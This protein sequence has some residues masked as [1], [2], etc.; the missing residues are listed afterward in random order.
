MRA[1]FLPLCAFLAACSGCQPT[2]APVPVPMP[3][4]PTVADAGTPP[5]PPRP[6]A[7]AAL[8]VPT[9]A[10]QAACANEVRLKC[11]ASMSVCVTT[12]RK[13]VASNLTALPLAC[14]ATMKACDE[15]AL[16]NRK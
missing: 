16:C 10:C 11:V 14:L 2:P 15:E 9:D 13:V 6:A 1:L 3:P 4:G 5:A 12:C 8:P 7:D